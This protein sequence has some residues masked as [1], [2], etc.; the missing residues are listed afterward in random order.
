M[1]PA[2]DK[3][4]ND[5]NEKNKLGALEFADNIY[6]I[7][8][9]PEFTKHCTDPDVRHKMIAGKY[10]EFA[11]AYP[12]VLR[13][14][15]RDLKY[16]RSAFKQFLDK[17][18]ID[19]GKGMEGFMCRQADYAKFLYYALHK[20]KHPNRKTAR[21]IWELEYSTMNKCYKKIIEN[22][23]NARNEFEDEANMYLEERRNELLE[24]VTSEEFAESN[25]P[26]LS[27][28][29]QESERLKWDLPLANPNPTFNDINFEELS[30]Q[31]KCMLCR[32]MRSYSEKL[33]ESLEQKNMLIEHLENKYAES[34]S[35]KTAV[36]VPS[37]K[38]QKIKKTPKIDEEWL[39]GTSAE[40]RKRRK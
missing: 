38:A 15:A 14:L 10:P 3:E 11:K 1:E 5:Q 12:V 32:E 17:L 20:G 39:I 18:E 7:I 37:K 31:E 40:K 16:E 33:F 21:A 34:S 23:K 27:Q 2:S 25:I 29:Q 9:N 13:L 28:N 19:P 24:F 36:N 22:E 30:F 4:L 8:T 35:V 6:K 26:K